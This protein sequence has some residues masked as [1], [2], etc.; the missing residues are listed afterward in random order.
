MALEPLR[1]GLVSLLVLLLLLVHAAS[2]A[3]ARDLHLEM[4]TTSAATARAVPS[5]A[6]WRL[7]VETNNIRDW[8]SIP[9]E[10]RGY[11]RDYMYGDLFRQDCAVVAREAAAYAEGLEL[12]GD[13]KEVWVFDVDDTTLSNLPYYADTGFGAEPYNATY[14]DEYVANATAPPL[15]EVLQLYETLL[16]L[17]IKVV[18]I[19][20]RHDYEKEPTI[21]NLRSAGYHTWDKLVLKPSS[22]GSSVVPYKSGERQKL[23]DAG[24]RI[25]G[26]MGDQWSDLIGAPEGDRTF[27]VPDPMYYVG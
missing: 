5:C 9:A 11:V 24:Y 2:A 3:R 8:Y 1:H 20:G 14:F 21:K 10:C 22:L 7:G 26:N 4:V 12:G 16:S 15:P 19:T 23:V 6:S 13:G 18:F 17:G 27:K 25:V